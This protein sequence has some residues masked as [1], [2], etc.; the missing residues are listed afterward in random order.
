MR[1]APKESRLTSTKNSDA[2]PLAGESLQES[3]ENPSQPRSVFILLSL[4]VHV[5]A[6]L[7]LVLAWRWG[8]DARKEGVRNETVVESKPATAPVPQIVPLSIDVA[9]TL[10]G[11]LKIENF[12]EVSKPQRQEPDL[13]PPIHTSKKPAPPPTDRRR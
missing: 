5:L 9:P 13:P 3:E 11:E 4:T 6:I 12:I 1:G 7:G 10:V 2:L 8:Q